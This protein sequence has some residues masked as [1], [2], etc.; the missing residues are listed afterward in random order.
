[1]TTH[2]ARAG[3]SDVPREAM[4]VHTLIILVE[5]RPGSI[6]RVIGVLRRRRAHLQSLALGRTEQPDIVRITA[7]IKDAE[8]SIDHVVE[9]LRKIVDVRQVRNLMARQ[10]VTHEL[11]LIKVNGTSENCN[12]IIAGGQRCGA[13]AVDIADEA[14]TL[15]MAGSTEQV[16]QLIDLLQPYGIREVARSGPVAMARG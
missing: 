16:E 14:V 11:A 3:H 6:D 1:M 12:E 5:E 4:Q 8:V 2:T 15:E 9:Q 13:H 10:A 7:V